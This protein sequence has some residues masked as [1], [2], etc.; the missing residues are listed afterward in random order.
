MLKDKGTASRLAARD[1]LIYFPM[2]ILVGII[3][4]VTLAQYLALF[5][6][7]EYGDYNV[8]NSTVSWLGLLL[9]GWM[10]Q[11]SLRY[12]DTYMKERK[13]KQFYSTLFIGWLMISGFGVIIG[14]SLYYG[15][16]NQ[17][18][19]R[20]LFL[21]KYATLS[22]ITF[23]SI[24]IINNLL[25][26]SRK[27]LIFTLSSILLPV[28]KLGLLILLVNKAAMGIEG[29]LFS[30]FI[31]DIVFIM[32]LLIRF[33]HVLKNIRLKYL[34][35]DTA[36]TFMRFGFP[37][38]GL[39]L[40]SSVLSFGDRYI[41]RIY[42]GAAE[43]GLYGAGYSVVS[44]AFEVFLQAFMIGLYPIILKTWNEQGKEATE[45]LVQKAFRWYMIL[46]VP[47]GLGIT[48]VAGTLMNLFSP[49]YYEAKSVIPWVAAGMVILGITQYTNKIWELME[50]PA[51]IL[52][53]NIAAAIINVILN[54]IF[55]PRYGYVAGGITTM[56]S[57]LLYLIFSILASRNLFKWGI[58]IISLSRIMVSGLIMLGILLKFNS[59]LPLSL[60]S[61]IV[62]IIVG[63]VV[64]FGVLYL[65]GEMKEEV[66]YIKQ[67]KIKIIGGNEQ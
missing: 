36:K 45:E 40:T 23:N 8:V 1:T 22:F 41:I 21:I 15:L 3:G 51:M 60:L 64:Y 17:V 56:V 57:Y 14:I 62:L 24:N 33:K 7:A 25:R 9:A 63:G 4:F 29:I 10:V 61:L 50:K 38:L 53:L 12:Y 42:R 20:I 39:A 48:A 67:T 35:L 5:K 47:A 66:Q 32:I 34:D 18:H 37:L 26:A 2:K 27:T 13:Q 31:I 16:Q 44:S 46:M 6:K 43:T 55:I 49:E 58:G 52:R 19:P 59:L 30:N 54:L 28:G 65:L 11:S